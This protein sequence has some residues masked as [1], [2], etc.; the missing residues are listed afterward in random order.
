M[1]YRTVAMT[2]YQG[3]QNIIKLNSEIFLVFITRPL[4]HVGHVAVVAST[5]GSHLMTADYINN[6]HG[7]IDQKERVGG[8]VKGRGGEGER[9]R[10]RIQF[11]NKL[12]RHD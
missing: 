1:I 7:D 4:P 6:S 11:H 12:Q 10:G 2:D 3:N 9:G 5:S 8:G